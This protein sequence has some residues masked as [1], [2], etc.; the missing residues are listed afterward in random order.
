MFAIGNHLAER[1]DLFFRPLHYVMVLGTVCKEVMGDSR[2]NLGCARH[3]YI[4]AQVAQTADV[5]KIQCGAFK[6]QL[7]TR[8]ASLS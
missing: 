6:F 5:V 3:N 7:R 2:C 4:T 8:Q 1:L